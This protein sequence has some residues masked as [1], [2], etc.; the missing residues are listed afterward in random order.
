M[1][2][3]ASRRCRTWA[4]GLAW[5]ALHACS[6]AGDS[7]PLMPSAV[8]IVPGAGSGGSGGLGSGGA[9]PGAEGDAGMGGVGGGSGAV[10]GGGGGSGSI[11]EPNHLAMRRRRAGPQPP[12]TPLH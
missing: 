9:G 5:L 12:V 4:L 2:V 10:S 11:G 7:L 1:R 3:H 8:V 6:S